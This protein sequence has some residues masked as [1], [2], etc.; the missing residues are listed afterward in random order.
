[1]APAAEVAVHNQARSSSDGGEL[2]KFARHGRRWRVRLRSPNLTQAQKGPLDLFEPGGLASRHPFR[3]S[4]LFQVFVPGST[5]EDLPLVLLRQLGL[6]QNS[7][8]S[9][10][11]CG[12]GQEGMLQVWAARPRCRVVLEVLA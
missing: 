5:P 2:T 7:L 10:K 6:V 4:N 11:D 8:R 9:R 3:G 12:R 1:M